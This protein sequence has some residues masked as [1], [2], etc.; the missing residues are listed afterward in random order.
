MKTMSIAFGELVEDKLAES[1]VLPFLSVW[2]G[3]QAFQ[4]KGQ[5]G[6][7]GQDRSSC[8]EGPCQGNTCASQARKHRRSTYLLYWRRLYQ[9]GSTKLSRVKFSIT[10]NHL[11]FSHLNFIGRGKDCRKACWA[12]PCPRTGTTSTIRRRKEDW[13]CPWG[14]NRWTKG[15]TCRGGNPRRRRKFTCSRGGCKRNRGFCHRGKEGSRKPRRRRCT[16]PIRLQL[17][18]NYTSGMSRE[19]LAR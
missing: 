7:E 10:H 19:V 13:G 8:Q 9:K 4:E 11:D 2:Q 1:H 5:E 12:H 18:W 17:L 14:T 3:F 15:R 16:N 6:Q